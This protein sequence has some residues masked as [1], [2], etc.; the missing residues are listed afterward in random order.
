[1]SVPPLHIVAADDVLERDDFVTLATA[2]LVAHGPSL[3]LH[4]RAHGRSGAFL[5]RIA[6]VLARVARDAGALLVVNDRVDVALSAGAAGVQLGARSLPVAAT[7]ALVGADVALGYSAHAAEEAEAAARAGA[8]WVLAGTIYETASHPG[9][10]GAGPERVR[11]IAGRVAVP[12]VAIGGITADRIA[13]VVAAGARG[14]AVVGAVWRAPEPRDAAAGL[15]AAL[16][17][18]FHG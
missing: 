8:D 10:A 15:L 11:E 3:A 12:V 2:L 16:A 13:E 1:M 17:S 18:A 5:Y 14:V 4:L 6:A 7:R 9:R